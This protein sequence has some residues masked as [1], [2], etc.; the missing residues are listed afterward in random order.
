MELAVISIAVFLNFFLVKW[1]LDTKRYADAVFDIFV[2]ATLAYLFN[3][4]MGGMVIAMCGGA[5][6]SIALIIFPPKFLQNW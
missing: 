5:L 6:I 4:S 2:L 3:G 1:K